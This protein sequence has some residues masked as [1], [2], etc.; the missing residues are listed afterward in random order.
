MEREEILTCI[1]KQKAERAFWDYKKRIKALKKLYQNIL[2]MKEDIFAA[3]KADLNKSEVESYTTEIG[4]VLCEISYMLRHIKKFSRPKKFRSEFFQFPAKSVITPCPYGCVL[5][6]SPWNYPFMLSI[7]PLVDAI[8]AGN[9]VVLKPS[10]YSHNTSCVIEKLVQKTFEPNEVIVVSGGREEN[11]F[12]MEQDFDYIFYTGSTAVGKIVMQ[13]AAEKFTP[14]TLEMGGK[15]PCIVDK[16]ADIPLAARRIVFGKFLNSGQTCVAPDFVYCDKAVKAQLVEELKKQI[17]IQYSEDPLTNE[18]YPKII[19]QKHFDKVKNYIDNDR[20]IYGGKVDEEKLK[21]QPTL[22]DSDFDRPE[23]NSEM[24]GPVLPIVTFE[25]LD[26]AIA[27]VNS[28][29]TPLALYFFSQSKQNQNEVTS[30]CKF[31]GGCINDTIMHIA[32]STLP[33]GGLKQSG[34]GKYHGKAGFDT[35]TH[36]KSIIDKKTYFDLPVRYQPYTDKH[37]KLIKFF[38]K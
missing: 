22:L 5:I 1:E 31:G 11:A 23:M 14:I 15:S 33:F 25:E 16:T 7:E 30:R 26:E 19:N 21:I 24:F 17:Q 10:R 8:S 32:S 38:M 29:S 36:Y 27:K 18:N 2:L 3:L 20:L 34:M 6:M 13:K 28:M 12:L 4:M 9:S 37:Y 35:F